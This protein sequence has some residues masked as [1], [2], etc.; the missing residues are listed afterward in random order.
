MEDIIITN[1]CTEALSLSLKA[2]SNFGDTVIVESPTDPWLRQTIKDSHLYALEIPANPDTGI[3]L[4]SVE[5]VIRQE[6]IAC[7]IVN[8]NCQNPLG[9]IMPDSHKKKL[10]EL[11]NEADIP[12][13]ENDVCGDL[14][15]GEYR[16]NPIK[17]W[18]TNNTVLY[19]SSFSKVL[20]AGLRVGWVAPGR[21]KEPIKRMKLNRSMISPTLNQS[22]VA[23]YLKDGT[24]HRHLR[25]LRKIIK[26][27]HSYC[28]SAIFK[29]F[30]NTVKMTS[31]LGGLSIWI[32]LPTGIKGI[33][34]YYEARNK[35]ISILP[36]FLCSSLD[37]YDR[38]IRIGYG[39]CWDKTTEQAIQT[40]GNI[41]KRI[42]RGH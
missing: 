35:G 5:K 42:E 34:V 33:D 1:G 39:G 32:E 6:K 23:N 40:I 36:G 25:K 24:Y 26:L 2:V 30:P 9:F 13:I 8:P 7:C 3:D 12:I 17:K 11:L 16:P 38:Y 20:A 14:F 21:F 27:Q 4:L 22:L 18:D 29:H 15:F 41:I 10:L 28:A 19:C 37:T 31:P